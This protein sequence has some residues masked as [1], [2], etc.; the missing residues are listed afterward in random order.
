MTTA[1]HASAPYLRRDVQEALGPTLRPGGSTTTER[2]LA[3]WPL[4]AGARVLDIGCGLGATVRLLRERYK[5]RAY[6]LD[7][8]PELLIQARNEQRD[9]GLLCGSAASIPLRGAVLDAVFMECV[10]SLCPDPA[11]ALAEAARVLRPGGVLV[12]SDVYRRDP[13]FAG[14]PNASGCLRGA[15]T[16][17]DLH[18]RIDAAGLSV[19]TWEDHSRLLVDCAA[20]LAFA[21]VPASAFLGSCGADG[22]CATSARAFGYAL[23]LA[24]KSITISDTSVGNA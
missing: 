19:L 6:G 8:T 20:R 9:A 11:A 14:G 12:L 4:P 18:A 24:E 5:L 21:G 2:A 17:Y 22:S 16:R 1:G 7:L 23:C 13:G 15:A 3:L 10:L